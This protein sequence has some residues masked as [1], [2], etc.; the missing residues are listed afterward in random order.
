MHNIDILNSIINELDKVYN[1]LDKLKLDKLKC[2]ILS[3]VYKLSD[4]TESI[5]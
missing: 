3:I 5:K 2:D 1:E 4:L